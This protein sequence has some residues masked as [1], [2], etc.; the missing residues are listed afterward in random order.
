V[1]DA[2]VVLAVDGNSLVHRAFHALAATGMRSEAGEPIWAV[3]GLL[4]QLV[5]AAERIGPRAIVVGFDDPVYSLRR[6]R[7]PHYKAQREE[8]LDSLVCQLETAA[9]IT[10]DLG[11]QVICPTGLEADDVLA[12]VAAAA[13]ECGARTVIA[14]SDRDAFAL[15]DE[16]TSVLRIING[17][18]EASPMLTPE[19]LVMLLGIRP[20]QYRDFAALRGDPSDNLP[21]VRGVGP[22]TAA[23]L[24]AE[25]GT[26]EAVFAEVGDGGTRLRDLVGPGM[27]QRLAAPIARQAWAHNCEVMSFQAQVDLQLDLV[28]GRGVIPLPPQRVRDIYRGQ[29]LP[30]TVPV[31]LR[32][33]CHIEI[34]GPE[35]VIADSLNWDPTA[36]WRIRRQPPL[37]TKRIETA[38]LS[39]F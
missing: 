23:K 31:A 22:K 17:G 27:A 28:R 9:Q 2:P 32:A 30:S 24:L 38:Q 1:T 8:K 19:R 15:I 16:H 25:F 26:A 14:T 20:D 13:A 12:A 11:L 37:P 5:S 6:E 34:E 7:W 10:R 29:Q 21:G 39:L 18:I 35:P 4:S 33:L 36:P 3:R